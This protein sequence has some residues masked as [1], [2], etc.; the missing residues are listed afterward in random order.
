[1]TGA[2]GLSVRSALRG[3][4]GGFGESCVTSKLRRC[5]YLRPVFALDR[6]PIAYVDPTSNEQTDIWAS[7]IA[8]SSDLLPTTSV[9]VLLGELVTGIA[10]ATFGGHPTCQ[11]ESRRPCSADEWRAGGNSRLPSGKERDLDHW[12]WGS[13]PALGCSGFVINMRNGYIVGARLAPPPL[14]PRYFHAERHWGVSDVST[15]VGDPA[16]GPYLLEIANN[17]AGAAPDTSSSS[18]S[19]PS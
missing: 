8:F 2:V 14:E 10:T 12:T 4:T 3:T 1:M 6:L 9:S 19:P 17:A 15:L 5:E 13:L 7:A 18:S 11:L 16:I